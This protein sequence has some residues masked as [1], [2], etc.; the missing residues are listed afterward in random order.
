MEGVR[1]EHGQLVLV[2]RWGAVGERRLPLLSGEVQ[3]WRMDPADWEPVLRSVRAEGIPIVA[4][5]LSWRRHAP[6]SDVLDLQGRLD[7]RLNVRR[8]LDLA[9]DFGLF[10]HLKP[11]PWICAEEPG[12]GYPDWLLE[13]R[14]LWAL[15]ATDRPVA[16]YNPPFKHPVPSCLHPRYLSQVRAWLRSVDAFLRDY[17]FPR[18]PIV[19][20]QLDNEPS[21]AFQDDMYSADYHPVALGHFRRWLRRRY[22]TLSALEKAWEVALPHDGAID[23]PRVPAEGGAARPGSG[24]WRQE[25]DW[26]EFK[27]WLLAEYLRRLRRYHLSA[28]VGGA[29][30]SGNY[31][32][33]RVHSVP[34]DPRRLRSAFRGVGGEDLYYIPPLR[35]EHIFHLA[36]VAAHLRSAGEP[37]PWA[38]EVQAGIWRSPG[39]RVDYPDPSVAEQRFYYLAALAFGL[40]GLN[41]YMLAQREN[42]DLAPLQ[43]GGESTP[44]LDAV[45]GAVSLINGVADWGGY[46]PETEVALHWYRAYALD[47][48][49]AADAG[50]EAAERR[51]LPY[52]E[53]REALA[54]LLR[55][56]HLP[57]VWDSRRSN[58]PPGVRVVVVPGGDYMPLELQLRLVR[59][60]AMGM[61]VLLF[62]NPPRLDADG[63]ECTILLEALRAGKGG[64]VAVTGRMGLGPA[65]AREGVLPPVLCNHPDAM[66]VLH[67]H[68]LKPDAP[69]LLYLLYYGDRPGEVGLHFNVLGHELERGTDGGTVGGVLEPVLPGGEAV[70]M[71]EGV[72]RLRLK[73]WT[74]SPYYVRFVDRK[75]PL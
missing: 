52:Q 66:A 41:F 58:P 68:A 45:R 71:T 16:G 18:G 29:V 49:A 55:A 10:V 12:G 32:A 33:H 62:G 25:H 54:G 23:A 20:V 22:G 19:L 14:D 30:F 74:V 34:Q 73:P 4:S 48:Y 21:Y 11:G 3:F 75:P 60:A 35:P 9:A 70:E 31:N 61:T 24:A 42:W 38:P 64:L 26:A 72:L 5:Y 1:V 51:M 36:T 15:D 69:P 8:F 59:L 28:G 13:D 44:M 53:W 43:S 67:R 47:A 57:Q 46:A 6:S 50:G 39:E 2:S 63:G 40:R 27:S 65:L 17:F 56:G 7:P 37:L